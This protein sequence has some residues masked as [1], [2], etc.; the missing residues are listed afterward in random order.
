MTQQHGTMITQMGT[1]TITQNKVANILKLK[2]MYYI[3]QE[4]V[5]R[6]ENYENLIISLDR[7]ELDYEIVKLIPFVDDFEFNTDRKDVFPFGA[8]KMSRISKKYGWYPGSQI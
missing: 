5:F 6:E 3:V 7:L 8:V 2:F 1:I 4:N